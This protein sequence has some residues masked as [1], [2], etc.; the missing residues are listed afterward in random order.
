VVGQDRILRRFVF[1]TPEYNHATSGALKNA[2][3]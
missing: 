3:D 1:V 2:I